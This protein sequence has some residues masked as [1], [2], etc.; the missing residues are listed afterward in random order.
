MKIAAE[1]AFYI[2]SFLTS[3]LDS[4]N[5]LEACGFSRAA[6]F[7]HWSKR[8]VEWSKENPRVAAYF[9]KVYGNEMQVYEVGNEYGYSVDMRALTC[10]DIELS[11]Q[12]MI[13][14]GHLLHTRVTCFDEMFD[15]LAYSKRELPAEMQQKA[16][17]NMMEIAKIMRFCIE[18]LDEI[19]AGYVN[20]WS[21]L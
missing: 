12:H 13:N 3:D 10:L 2:D 6:I 19:T 5:W 15:S 11:A 18:R 1:I 9:N 8:E 20:Q 7:Q 16:R 4:M 14:L 21:G 17:E